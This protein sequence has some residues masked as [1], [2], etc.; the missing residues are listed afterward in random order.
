MRRKCGSIA[1]LKDVLESEKGGRGR[2]HPRWVRINTIKAGNAEGV[3]KTLPGASKKESL[4]EVLEDSRTGVLSYHIDENI[5]NL[6]AVSPN[7][8]LTTTEAY[9]SGTLILQDKASCFPAHLLLSGDQTLST[10]G[11]MIDGCAAPGNKTTHLAAITHTHSLTLPHQPSQPQSHR[12]IFACERDPHRSK[13]LQTM[14]DRAGAKLVDV[15]ARQDF[16]AL[17]PGDERFERVTHLLLDPSCSGSGILGREDVPILVLPVDS[18]LVQGKGKPAGLVS[19]SQSSKK[20]K[21]NANGNGK[22]DEVAREIKFAEAIPLAVT[23][24]A[25]EVEV[26]EESTTVSVTQD[27]LQKLSNLQS[28]IVE[29]AMTFPSAT[30]I[31]YSTCSIHEIENEGVVARVLKSR[32]ARERGWR[33]LRREEQVDGMRRWKSRGV[34]RGEK[35]TNGDGDEEVLDQEQL[36]A[37]IR[38]NPDDEE[39]TM[40][41]FVC[42]FVRDGDGDGPVRNGRSVSR[43]DLPRGS[44][45]KD[46]QEEVQEDEDDDDRGEWEGFD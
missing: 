10:T 22:E 34:A 7:F 19:T 33:V 4:A 13:T 40:G 18:R 46:G 1:Q 41:F 39:G 36:D 20:R 15:L 45:G 3:I 37:C 2:T 8:D 26:E 17:D 42:G 28:L 32:V 43:D 31:T 30:R 11:D 44:N 23:T 29:H 6:F 12:K 24:D 27:R 9:K 35:D 38:C 21:R 14:I 25:P 5:P 16:L